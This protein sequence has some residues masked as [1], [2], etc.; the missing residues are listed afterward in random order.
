MA[1][2]SWDSGYQDLLSLTD[3]I[4]VEPRRAQASLCMLF[5]IVHGLCLFPPNM[6]TTVNVQTGNCCSS[7]H[8][9]VPLHI[10][11]HLYHILFMRG[12]YSVSLLLIYLWSILRV[13]SLTTFLNPV[14]NVLIAPLLLCFCLIFCASFAFCIKFYRRVKKAQDYSCRQQM[15]TEILLLV[16]DLSLVNMHVGLP[17]ENASGVMSDPTLVSACFHLAE[18]W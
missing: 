7:N 13:T 17:L 16:F 14:H 8:L 6:Q 3:I 5:K 18:G 1:T 11:T 2:K 15:V 4:A 12:T 10:Y 9:L